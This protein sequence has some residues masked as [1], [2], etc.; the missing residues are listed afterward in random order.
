L[1][2]RVAPF[3]VAFTGAFAGILA[4]AFATG[5]ADV[6][7]AAVTGLRTAG[8]TA[9]AAGE[10]PFAPA[11][12]GLAGFADLVAG[13]FTTGLLSV[14]DGAWSGSGCAGMGRINQCRHGQ[15]SGV[16]TPT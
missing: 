10:R 11:T 12:A 15:Q 5:L 2:A 6:L 3:T 9:L 8:T 4:T 16:Y 1:G 14:P 13:A 7:G